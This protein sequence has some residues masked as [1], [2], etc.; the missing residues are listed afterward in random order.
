MT[1]KNFVRPAAL[2]IVC[3]ALAGLTALKSPAATN[4]TSNA[5]GSRAGRIALPLTT[6]PPRGA[7]VLFSGKSEDLSANWV[8]RY[9]TEAP[10][11]TV[12]NGIAM[13]RR[14]DITSKQEFGD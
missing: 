11:W 13:P 2:L 8:R 14:S 12:E 6:T 10:R 7:V 4:D 5:S 1:G 9:S 3:G